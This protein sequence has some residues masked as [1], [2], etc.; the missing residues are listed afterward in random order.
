MIV[1][2]VAMLPV[3]ARMGDSDVARRNQRPISANAGGP[4]GDKGREVLLVR[5]ED[6]L[7]DNPAKPEKPI[8]PG[9]NDHK[10]STASAIPSFFET[11]ESN[12]L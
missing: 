2:A 5:G 6:L 1:R 12:G 11:K 4:P 7:D 10:G 3:L 8:R 9:R